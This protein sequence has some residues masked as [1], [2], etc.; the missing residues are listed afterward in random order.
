MVSARCINALSNAVDVLRGTQWTM[1]A[2]SLSSPF[3]PFVWMP[4]VEVVADMFASVPV[5]S[6]LGASVCCWIFDFGKAARQGQGVVGRLTRESSK[7]IK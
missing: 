1:I 3:P 7:S 5:G 2:S 4:L 6:R